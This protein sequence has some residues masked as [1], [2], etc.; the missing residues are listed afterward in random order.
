MKGEYSKMYLLVA[1]VWEM[2]SKGENIMNYQGRIRIGIRLG[3]NRRVRILSGA[4]IDLEFT[5]D[6]SN[7]IF[8]EWQKTSVTITWVKKAHLKQIMLQK[9]C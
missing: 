9:D 2:L 7:I 4:Y 1:C 3:K 5:N 8:L 6:K